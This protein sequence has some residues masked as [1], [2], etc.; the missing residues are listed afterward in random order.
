MESLSA[1]LCGKETIKFENRIVQEPGPGEVQLSMRNVGLCGS[2]VYMYK[3]GCHGTHRLGGS[4]ILGHE[5]SAVVTKVGE[6]VTKLKVGDRVALEPGEACNK[7]KNCLRDVR[8][9]C[10][11]EKPF[12]G[13]TSKYDGYITKCKLMRADYCYKLPDNVSDEEGALMEPLAVAV[14]DCRRAGVEA[15]KSVLVLGSGTIGLLCMITAKA[16]G[17]TNVCITDVVEERLKLAKQLGATHTVLTNSSDVDSVVKE[18]HSIMGEMPDI[19]IEC[20]GNNFCQRLAIMSTTPG[21]CVAIVGYGAEEVTLPLAVLCQRQI[22]LRPSWR[23]DQHCYP[24]AIDMVASGKVNIKPLVTH[25]FTLE[26]TTDAIQV[27]AS[28]R[29]GVLKCMITCNE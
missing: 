4:G 15:G 19:T 23:Y 1:V 28:R 20:T 22:D 7:C 27:A 3:N 10:L 16:M 29:P 21:G 26:Q 18:I 14:Q 6:G 13:N 9:M 5:A 2:D 12:D 25:R 8:N 17:A 11:T 24:I